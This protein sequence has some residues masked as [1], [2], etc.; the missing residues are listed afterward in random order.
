M[1]RIPDGSGSDIRIEKLLREIVR[2]GISYTMLK[3]NELHSE[4]AG[5][6]LGRVKEDQ[7]KRYR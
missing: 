6:P 2:A 1:L 3:V 7:D 4:I 5:E